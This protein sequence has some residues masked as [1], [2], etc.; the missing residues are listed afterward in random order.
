MQKKSALWLGFLFALLLPLMAACAAGGGNSAPDVT[1]PSGEMLYVLAG[2]SGAGQ[3]IVALHPGAAAPLV[4]LP[5]GITTLDHQRLY[6]AVAGS[7]TTTIMV[8]DTR[9]GARLHV[10]AIAGR[11]A[12]DE[13]GYGNAVL[14]PDGR[15]LALRDL[16]SGALQTTIA[17]VDTQTGKVAKLIKQPDDF[18]L[19]A[20]SP[21][22]VTLYLLQQLHD[23]EHHYYVRD[24]DVAS[25]QLDPNIIVD[26]TDFEQE[27]AGQAVTRQTSGSVAHT[28]YLNPAED[29]AFIHIL[30]LEQGANFPFARCIDLPGT[31]SLD[32]LASYTLSLAPNGT[33]LYAANAV[34][35][36][37]V[38]IS[39]NGQGV[40]DDNITL[41]QQFT[42]GSSVHAA[43]LYNGSALSPDGKTLYVAGGDGIWA[44]DAQTLQVAQHYLAG[45]A[46]SSVA[47]SADG[48]SLYALD[49]ARGMLVLNLASGQA[50]QVTS[51]GLTAPVGIAW[52]SA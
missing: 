26:K 18:T 23:A 39:L 5:V 49:P 47:L 46:F 15:W 9:T 44:F 3:Q 12:S 36:M 14:S 21:D 25:G 4:K 52:V 32:V 6:T 31:G 30:P 17:V 27:M 22:G 38:K 7:G 13:E 29:K 51:A 34:L 2:A 37:V 43:T 24:F 40:F 45:E 19:D 48:T 50:S 33:Y 10:F 42:P 16:G 28:L 11:Y 1:K 20:I 41:Q 35:G 8:Y